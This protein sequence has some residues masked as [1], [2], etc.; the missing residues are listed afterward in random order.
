MI[1]KPWGH[2]LENSQVSTT[3]ESHITIVERLGIT[4]DQRLENEI[5]AESGVKISNNGSQ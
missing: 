3:L 4:V 1:S 2:T 5:K